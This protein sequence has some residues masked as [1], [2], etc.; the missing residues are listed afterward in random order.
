M[1]QELRD[2]IELLER[3]GFSVSEKRLDE[4]IDIDYEDRRVIYNSSHQKNVDTSIE[5]NP[6]IDDS[7]LKG[8]SVWSVFKRKLGGLF[9]GNPLIYALKGE[10]GWKFRSEY[11]KLQ[12]VHQF[13][14]IAEK[15]VNSHGFDISIIIPST[16][17]LNRYIAD[18]V[19]SKA[20]GDVRVL[21]DVVR[22]LTVDEVE[23]IIQHPKSKF[24]RVYGRDENMLNELGRYFDDMRRYKKGV[25]VRHMVK[26]QEIREL[27]DLTMKLSEDKYAEYANY[28]NGHDVLIIDDTISRGQSIS[29]ML[30]IIKTSYAPR[31][32]TVLTLMSK[33]Y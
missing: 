29:E 5:N 10:K 6:T 22:K 33:L 9:D 7:V 1:N 20:D 8:V 23:D 32:I 21:E 25:F 12:I 14:S 30:N 3:S 13:E 24:F 16:N 11:D 31:S 4:G 2:A 17:S 26:D 15:F 19:V 27:L 18:T 28:I